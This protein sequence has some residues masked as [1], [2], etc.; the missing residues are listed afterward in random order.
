M[1][2]TIFKINTI[3]GMTMD[4]KKFTLFLN[5]TLHKQIKLRAVEESVS[6]NELIVK[7]IEQYLEGERKAA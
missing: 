5:S 2:Y 7:A 3:K 4:I 1:V 6:M